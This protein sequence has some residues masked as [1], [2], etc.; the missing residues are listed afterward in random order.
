[1]RFG[2]VYKLSVNETPYFLYGSTIQK[3]EE[4]KYDYF[5]KLQKNIY[6]NLKLQ[7]IYNKYGKDSLI[8]T[9][10]Q[11]NIPEEI[12][13]DVESIWIGANK[14]RIEDNMGGLNMRDGKRVRFTEETKKKMSLTRLGRKRTKET[15]S[16]I[17][18]SHKG[19]KKSSA[20]LLN[21]SIALKG[22]NKSPKTIEKM[23]QTLTGRKLSKE[24]LEKRSKADHV[25]VN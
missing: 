22:K 3:L 16:K 24:T 8:F 2:I 13:G 10:V 23:R 18:N 5:S 21:L 12:L 20:H 11:E 25:P 17:S 7:N 6:G 19:K 4:R 1:M 15:K 14:G 9:V